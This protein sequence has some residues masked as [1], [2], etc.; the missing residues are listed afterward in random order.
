MRWKNCW[1]CIR[2]STIASGSKLPNNILEGKS[3]NR[4]P[5]LVL[6]YRANRRIKTSLKGGSDH[7]PCCTSH[8]IRCSAY[9]SPT[10]ILRWAHAPC[11]TTKQKVNLFEFYY[12]FSYF[13][14][15]IVFWSSDFN[16]TNYIRYNIFTTYN[17]WFAA[18]VFKD[19][20]SR[21]FDV[22]CRLHRGTLTI[23]AR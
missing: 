3:G 18:L 13:F 10:H 5:K 6:I 7:I 22:P 15:S 20:R 9:L 4:P 14:F 19:L 21:Y 12:Y 2:L 8:E 11:M 1:S 17:V 16:Q 23:V